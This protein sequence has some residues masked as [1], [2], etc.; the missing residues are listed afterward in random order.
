LLAATIGE[1]HAFLGDP[2]DVGRS[3]AHHPNREG[4]DVRLADVV[5]PDDEDLRPLAL[6]H[7]G[8]NSRA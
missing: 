7:G 8:P 3:I 2:V 5:A 1:D 6:G 4:Q